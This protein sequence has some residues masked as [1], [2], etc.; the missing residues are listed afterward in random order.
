MWQSVF[1]VLN[2]R[3]GVEPLYITTTQKFMT[4]MQIDWPR[5]IC[6]DVIDALKGVSSS[7]VPNAARR[8]VDQPLLHE[9]SSVEHHILGMMSRMDPG[10]LFLYNER[11]RMYKEILRYWGGMLDYYMPGFVLLPTTP[12]GIYDYIV[13]CLCQ[14]MKIPVVMFSANSFNRFFT[15]SN[16]ELG[17]EHARKEYL[18]TKNSPPEVWELSDRDKEHFDQIANSKNADYLFTYRRYQ[19]K[20]TSNQKHGFSLY[21]GYARQAIELPWKLWQFFSYPAPPHYLKRKGVAIELSKYSGVE[22]RLERLRAQLKKQTLARQYASMCHRPDL[23]Q[24]YIYIPLHY[25]PENTTCPNGD[26]YDDQLLMI[27]LLSDTLP[28]GWSLYVKEYP[29]QFDYKLK[30]E[31]SRDV[32]YYNDLADIP[33]VS[34]CPLEMNTFELIDASRGVATVTGS[35]GWESVCRLKPTLIFGNAWYESCDGVLRIRSSQDSKVALQG[36]QEGM[37]VDLKKVMYFAYV[38]E[39]Y[40]INGFA[41][42]GWAKQFQLTLDQ[43]INELALCIAKQVGLREC[44]A[45]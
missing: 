8:I 1:R 22:W 12:H 19:D 2:E 31:R 36:I 13:Y 45:I 11:F 28:G 29:N 27:Q 20:V 4:E 25:Q 21:K 7:Q 42:I 30:G 37:T 16:I 23:A 10:G 32:Q 3:Y 15:L 38:F 39:K 5:S 24:P 41:E 34:L 33:N 26:Y 9:F 6:H 35:A 40:C 43:N 18:N 17:L 14:K 44:G